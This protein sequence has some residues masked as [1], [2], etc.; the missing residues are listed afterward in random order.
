MPAS[1]AATASGTAKEAVEYARAPV[2]IGPSRPPMLLTPLI[3]PAADPDKLSR[4]TTSW[5]AAHDAPLPVRCPKW[6]RTGR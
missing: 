5:V 6:T 4:R 3:S 1:P 2:T